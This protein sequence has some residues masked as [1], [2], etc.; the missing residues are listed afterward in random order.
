MV[1]S[2]DQWWSVV[3]SG[4][5]GW[6]VVTSGGCLIWTLL[7]PTSAVGVF[8]MRQVC[9]YLHWQLTLGLPW[10][11]VC[12]I[13]TITRDWEETRSIAPPILTKRRADFEGRCAEVAGNALE[14]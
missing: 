4:E 11:S 10:R 2:G 1:I 5:Q 7:G 12:S 13:V 9:V 6:P 8:H 14:G 3:I